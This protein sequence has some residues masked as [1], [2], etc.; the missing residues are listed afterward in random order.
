MDRTSSWVMTTTIAA[1]LTLSGSQMTRRCPDAVEY[2]ANNLL[3]NPEYM[4]NPGN[5]ITRT[6][7]PITTAYDHQR[8][9]FSYRE[10]IIDRK[11][12]SVPIRTSPTVASTPCERVGPVSNRTPGQVTACPAKDP[13]PALKTPSAKQCLIAGNLCSRMTCDQ[14]GSL[15][16][17]HWC[18]VKAAFTRHALLSPW[19]IVTGHPSPWP[20]RDS[21]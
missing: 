2:S 7:W 20:R 11:A 10:T 5:G 18:V 19:S 8:E 16:R 21:S 4:A 12:G 13:P 17:S 6:D 15:S 14:A 9:E 3:F 1:L